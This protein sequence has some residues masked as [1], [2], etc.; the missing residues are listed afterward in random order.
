MEAL[1]VKIHVEP[2][3]SVT[4]RSVRDVSS[5]ACNDSQ[6][7]NRS[8]IELPGM[9][10]MLNQRVR[11]YRSDDVTRSI[12]EITSLT[13]AGLGMVT[14]ASVFEAL[15]E[16]GCSLFP[17]G[18]VIRDQ[19]LGK[20]PNDIDLK[21][22]DCSISQVLD[23]CRQRW[24]EENCI[25]TSSA[26]QM[27]AHI[28]H[29]KSEALDFGE[30]SR[31]FY[32]PLIYLEYT[33]NSLVY[34]INMSI[35]LDIAGT[36]VNDVC[37]KIIRIPSDDNSEMSWRDEWYDSN[38]TKKL[39]RFWKLRVKNFTA[40]N[41]NTT[42]FIV[43]EAQA[44]IDSQD[45]RGKDFKIF[46]CSTVYGGAMLSDDVCLV[47]NSTVCSEN[48]GLADAYNRTLREDM[49]SEYIDDLGLPACSKYND[50]LVLDF[51]S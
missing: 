11:F 46:Y 39:Y 29:P 6:M 34:W 4:R 13:V 48:Q 28:G 25:V 16:E 33:V 17:H 18:G 35:I 44:A 43:R 51:V 9:L 37:A 7:I 31:E 40:F 3:L 12:N 27:F 42:R 49:G 19:F 14:V 24:G 22:E 15:T 36:G 2:D 10:S 30:A 23:V 38:N 32:G 47:S 41:V 26:N 50:V 20:S 8:S 45:P 1:H 5:T 21:I